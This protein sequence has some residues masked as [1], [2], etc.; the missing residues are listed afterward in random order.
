MQLALKSLKQQE[1]YEFQANLGY[2][3][4]YELLRQ[5]K[6]EKHKATKQKY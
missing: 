6:E 3:L 5:K 1:A 4:H 2:M